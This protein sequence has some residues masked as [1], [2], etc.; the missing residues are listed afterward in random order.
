MKRLLLLP[1]A[2]LMPAAHA[3]DYVKCDAMQKALVR[4]NLQKDSVGKAAYERKMQEL[5]G[6]D[7]ACRNK[8][9]GGEMVNVVAAF[10]AKRAAEAAFAEKI[11]KI[12][13]DIEQ[14][15]CP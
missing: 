3:V 15:G 10:Q 11:S 5:C 8:S 13:S 4:V 7:Y 9:V 1:F 14:E 12:E 2:L 6:F